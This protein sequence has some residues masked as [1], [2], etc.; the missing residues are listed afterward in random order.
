MFE[1]VAYRPEHLAAL[2]LQEAQAFLGDFLSDEKMAQGIAG[3]WSYTGLL[4]GVPVGV[5]GLSEKWPGVATAWALFAPDIPKSA[6]LA[7]TRKCR[8]VVDACG[9]KR[10]EAAVREDHVQGHRFAKALRF[11]PSALMRRW[12]PD[13]RDYRLYEVV[14]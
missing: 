14:R 2:R 8:A 12:G 10:I 4:D 3:P 5:A 11:S 7:I 9:F 6:W 1:I 13:G